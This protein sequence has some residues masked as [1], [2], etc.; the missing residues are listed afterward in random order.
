[1]QIVSHYGIHFSNDGVGF[2]QQGRGGTNALGLRQKSPFRVEL[3]N[4]RRHCN[5]QVNIAAPIPDDR[6][7][8]FFNEIRR[9]DLVHAM[10]PVPKL[11]AGVYVIEQNDRVA[12]M[13]ASLTRLSS[14][15]HMPMIQMW[16]INHPR[17][18]IEELGTTNLQPFVVTD[19]EPKHSEIMADIA[20]GATIAPRKLVILA[21]KGFITPPNAKKIDTQFRE[22][23]TLDLETFKNLPWEQIGSQVVKKHMRKEP[24]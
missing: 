18:V 17:D 20:R 4:K 11:D 14:P 10:L 24:L 6:H 12:D 15:V 3:S 19:C 16:G 7:W 22:E 2:L 21:Q 1:M 8:N 5:H 13:V 23:G 9:D